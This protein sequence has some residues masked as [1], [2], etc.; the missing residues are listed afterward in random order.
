MTR[1]PKPRNVARV[2]VTLPVLILLAVVGA[3]TVAHADTVPDVTGLTVAEA[4][5]LLKQAG[6]AV[7][8]TYEV[9]KPAQ[10]VFAQE[11]P[12]FATRP[13]GTSVTLRAGRAAQGTSPVPARSGMVPNFIGRA[14][15]E[16]REQ[17]KSF[18]GAREEHSL[19][20]PALAGK[21]VHQWP[22]AGEVVPEGDHL[23]VVIGVG[24]RPS[25][26]HK[27]VPS[28]DGRTADAARKAARAAGFSLT[29]EEVAAPEGTDRLVLAQF[30]LA[31][32]LAEAGSAL[33][34]RIPARKQT[35]TAPKT[36]PPTAAPAPA[37]LAAPGLVLPS[38]E[39]VRRASGI[40]FDW[41]IVTGAQRYELEVERERTGGSWIRAHA[42]ITI[43][44][45]VRG[46][47]LPRGR[48]RW[49]VRARA[50]DNAAGPWSPARRF[51]VF[52]E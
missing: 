46:V 43:S 24:E 2:R 6:F 27:T 11:P 45:Y 7:T 1:P 16:A 25:D 42:T 4:R 40:G 37:K 39:D 22:S 17:M 34:V 31:G 19:V 15:A 12:G 26:R 47:A 21:V 41:R 14:A 13:A 30:P 9:G 23:I 20:I 50:G 29:V 52:G 48:Y 36:P 28:L 3:P 44:P 10:L 18:L 35:P 38:A 5:T 33:R 51:Y 8:V 32:S 49:R